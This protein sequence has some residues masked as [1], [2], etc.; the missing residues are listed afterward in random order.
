MPARPEQQ[1]RLLLVLETDAHGAGLERLEA[2]LK[3]GGPA[4]ACVLLRSRPGG[5][6]AHGELQTAIHRLQDYGIAVLLAGDPELALHL[7]A[8]GAHLEASDD[9]AEARAR[10]AIAR[11]SLGG[12]R[13]V[14]ASAGHSRHMA[15]VLGEIGAD[16]VAFEP[17]ASGQARETVGEL[18]SWWAQ[19]TEVPAVALGIDSATEADRLAA[20]GVDFI[21]VDLDQGTAAA[22]ARHIGLMAEAISTGGSHR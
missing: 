2:V 13:T 5:S 14:G 16:Y 9:E 12:D 10:Y 6:L 22:L 4:I 3:A 19:V 7:G 15:M 1:A 8:D 18:A 17:D 20:S 21:G 11:A